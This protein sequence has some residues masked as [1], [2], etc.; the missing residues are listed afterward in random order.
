MIWVFHR[1]GE[2]LA[3]EVRTCPHNDGFELVLARNG[4]MDREWYPNEE[5]VERR[6]GAL[7]QQLR[8][9]GWGEMF[10]SARDQSR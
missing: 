3:C 9:S 8:E 5:Q 6:W 1:L 4:K 7:N 2:Y 10:G